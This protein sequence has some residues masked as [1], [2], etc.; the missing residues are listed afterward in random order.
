MVT[1][2]SGATADARISRML[3]T[4][5]NSTKDIAERP[6]HQ[7]GWSCPR[8]PSARRSLDRA[9]RPALR[10]DALRMVIVPIVGGENQAQYFPRLRLV[11]LASER[12]PR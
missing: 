1:C 12:S 8:A 6:P 2:A 3:L 10:L 9:G 4:T 5:S 11:S 7:A